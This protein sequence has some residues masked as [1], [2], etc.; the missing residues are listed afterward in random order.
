MNRVYQPRRVYPE[1][2]ALI[3]YL[4][5]IKRLSYAQ[6]GRQIGRNHSTV[7]LVFRREDQAEERRL[8]AEEEGHSND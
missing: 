6:I 5:R 2:A 8:Q 7:G 4:Y 1:E 3:V